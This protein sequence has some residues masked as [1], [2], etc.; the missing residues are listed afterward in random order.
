MS[1]C[2]AIL[3]QISLQHFPQNEYTRQADNTYIA[4]TKGN[5]RDSRVGQEREC[6]IIQT[7]GNTAK[8]Q[9]LSSYQ[10]DIPGEKLQALELKL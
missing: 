8:R 6:C 1:L 3:E 4:E 10:L 7:K 2:S 9:V 5:H